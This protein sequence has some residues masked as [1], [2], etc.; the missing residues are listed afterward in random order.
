VGPVYEQ[1]GRA[2]QDRDSQIKLARKKCKLRSIM[3]DA[4]LGCRRSG[5]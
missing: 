2:L 4:E 1:M 5:N 3:E